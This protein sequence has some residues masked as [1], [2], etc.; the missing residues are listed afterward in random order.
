[1][2]IAVA[3]LFQQYVVYSFI[4]IILIQ[5]CTQNDFDVSVYVLSAMH[6]CSVKN[7]NTAKNEREVTKMKYAIP[8][9]IY[10][11][12]QSIKKSKYAWQAK[13]L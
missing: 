12:N 7:Q 8:M 13:F 4:W 11:K 1:M 5:Q 9:K 6:L 2:F 3:F 10:S